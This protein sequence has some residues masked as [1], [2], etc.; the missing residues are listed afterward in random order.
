M[1]IALP[2]TAAFCGSSKNPSSSIVARVFGDKFNDK[3][4]LYNNAEN[5]KE[6]L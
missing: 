6:N 3:T 2:D 5:K 4:P 1:Y